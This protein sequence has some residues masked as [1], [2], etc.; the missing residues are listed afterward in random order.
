MA[1]ALAAGGVLG[2]SSTPPLAATAAP[3]GTP[4]RFAGKVVNITGGTSGIG[5]AAARA[6]AAE[7]ALVAFCG[8]REA[9]GNQV[10][11]EIRAAGGEATYIQADVREEDQVEAFI[12]QAVERYGGLHIALNNA[13][14]QKPFSSLHEQ[15]VDDF[16]DTFRTNVRGVYLAMKAQI[17]H[18]LAGGGGSIV[19]TS[20]VAVMVARP[21]LAAYAA[22][23]E[24]LQGLVRA[25]ALEYGQH[26][27][28]INA[29]LPGMTDTP[30]VRPADLDDAT[31]AIGRAALGRLN[32]DGLGRLATAEEIASAALAIASDQF[33]Y[34]T[35]AS[36]AVD[37]GLSAGR[38]LVIPELEIAR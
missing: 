19:V 15:S 23:K 1:S 3:A 34:M 5:A 35:G 14:I 24:A 28:R 4:G 16:D 10:E 6:F 27:I 21:G 25:A 13:G 29:L 32:V 37:G 11:A 8:R 26:G 20:S 31:W 17:P 36:I 38:P 18:M 22:S 2:L 7:G 12:S 9:L 33:S 30:M